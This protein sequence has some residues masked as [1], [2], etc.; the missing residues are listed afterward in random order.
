MEVEVEVERWCVC[1]VDL[2][3]EPKGTKIGEWRSGGVAIL[4][5][6]PETKKEEGTGKLG[7]R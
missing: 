3:R 4:G 5:L 6:G 1:S 2:R 7:G